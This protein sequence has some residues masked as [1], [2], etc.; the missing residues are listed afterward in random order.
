MKDF[1]SEALNTINERLYA[2][3]LEISSCESEL[4]STLAQQG[5]D[6][7][8]YKSLEDKLGRL[9][10]K[11]E[12][13]TRSLLKEGIVISNPIS[14][15]QNLMDTLIT[16]ESHLSILDILFNVSIFSISSLTVNK[17]FSSLFLKLSN[18]WQEKKKKGINIIDNLIIF[19][20]FINF[21]HSFF[22]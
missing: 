16:I 19:F 8:A 2:L 7:K 6:H 15:R 10:Q 4:I 17:I 9:K 5:E 18:F 1:V 13:E 22:Y 21:F 14:Y 12:K 11:L 3:K 20:I